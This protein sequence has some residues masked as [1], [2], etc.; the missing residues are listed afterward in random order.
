MRA[1]TLVD[2]L[3]AQGWGFAIDGHGLRIRRPRGALTDELRQAL[4][5]EKAAIMTILAAEHVRAPMPPRRDDIAAVKVWSEVLQEAVW[6]V[7]DDVP[8]DE[9]LADGR[10]YTYHEVRVLL[11]QG[12]GVKAWA[13][14][15]TEMEG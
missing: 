6:V 14:L 8:L 7:A 3:R 1:T 12:R 15:D 5:A 13:P 10:V 4:L 2:T 11:E 9:Y